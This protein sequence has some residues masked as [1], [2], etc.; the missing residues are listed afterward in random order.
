M[1]I[2]EESAD[3][4]QER[5]STDRVVAEAVLLLNSAAA[6]TAVFVPVVSRSSAPAPT[7][8]SKLWSVRRKTESNRP[9]Y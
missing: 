4:V 2:V 7:P 5:E 1:G 9:P 6:P 8:V 3:I